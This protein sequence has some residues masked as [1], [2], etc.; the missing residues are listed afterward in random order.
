[1]RVKIQIVAAVFFVSILLS[2]KA[3]SDNWIT[4]KQKGYKIFYT[5]I[6]KQNKREYLKLVKNGIESVTAF[7]S[8]PF[9][10]EFNVVVHPNRQSLDSTWQRDW[11]MPEFK[12]ECWMV[13]SGTASKLDMISPKFWDH[14]S[15][16]HN[17]TNTIKTQQLITHELV[18]VYHGQYNL[19]PDFSDVTGIDWFVEG[20]ATYASGQYDSSRMAEVKSAIAENRVS[21]SLDKFWTG[22]LKYGLSGSVVKYIDDK[23]GRAKL[24]ELLKYNKLSDLLSSLS[25]TESALLNEWKKE[26]TK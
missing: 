9:N 14:E 18:H 19:S 3:I 26:L 17:Y 13:A 1:M 21:T 2:W 8:N 22:K 5:S 20:L 24:I 23:Y 12:S 6:D 16:E 7:F 10:N 25:T 11:Q 4:E 15:C